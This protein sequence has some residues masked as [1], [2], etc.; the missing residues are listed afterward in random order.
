MLGYVTL[1]GRTQT[2]PE[3]GLH[4]IWETTENAGRRV[5]GFMMHVL[6]SPTTNTE[7]QKVRSQK[8]QLKLLLLK[9]IFSMNPPCILKI[10]FDDTKSHLSLC[11][12]INLANLEV[13]DRRAV[14]SKILTAN[15][16]S[17]DYICRNQQ[18]WVIWDDSLSAI[19]IIKLYSNNTNSN[20][21]ITFI[22]VKVYFQQRDKF[23][24][25][26]LRGQ[27]QLG[28]A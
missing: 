7:V 24:A 22:S 3:T 27:H 25:V 10:I 14:V 9:Q 21:N 5:G 12:C 1:H 16:Q 28:G 18:R 13:S 8:L 20:N 17:T 15:C 4:E 26:A 2:L 19:F 23:R 6:W 11:S